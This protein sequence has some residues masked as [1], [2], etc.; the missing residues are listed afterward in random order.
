MAQLAKVTAFLVVLL[1]VA[2]PLVAQSDAVE[3]LDEQAGAAVVVEPPASKTATGEAPAEVPKEQPVAAPDVSVAV[4]KPYVGRIV[5]DRVNV[6]SGPAEVYYDVTKI[7]KG[8]Q[9]VVREEKQGWCKIEPTAGCF[10]Y[11]SMEFVKVGE[12]V[13]AVKGGAAVAT[14]AGAAEKVGAT[15]D[16]AG[17]DQ[18]AAAGESVV[19]PGAP[20]VAVESGEAKEA[21]ASGEALASREAD[22]GPRVGTVTGDNV[23]VRAGSVKVPPQYA[24]E[25]QTK[26]SRGDKVQIIGQR[27]EFYKIVTPANCYFWVAGDFVERVGA[28]TPEALAQLKEQSVSVPALV[29]EPK[30]LSQQRVEYQNL[31]KAIKAERSKPL[32]KQSFEALRKRLNSLVKQTESVSLKGS[33]ENLQRHLERCEVA[34]GIWQQSRQED[35]QLSAKLNEIDEQMELLTAVKPPAPNNS[36]DIVVNGTLAESAVFTAPNKNRRFL[37]LD[38]SERIIY[39]AIADTEGVELASYLGKQV[40]MVGQVQYDAFGKVRLL[41]VHEVVDLAQGKEEAAK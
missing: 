40:R 15:G 36:K 2:V 21:K 28:I 23:R 1:L 6:R 25:V 12:A 30:N 16:E 19:A 20:Y 5:A 8:R 39:Y 34:L 3:A 4:F 7:S 41:H 31:A 14:E 13:D 27:G 10:S 17:T 22:A 38:E 24:S 11:I 18:A 26:L 37:V 35:R 9:V 32:A 29:E 33:V